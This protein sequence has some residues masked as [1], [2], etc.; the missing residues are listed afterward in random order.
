M[1]PLLILG[2]GV[3]AEEVADLAE[4]AGREIAGFVE[5]R[6][7]SRCTERLRSLPIHWIDDIAPL[8]G[9]CDAVCAVGS[10]ARSRF[11]GQARALGLGFVALAHP[12]AVVFPSASVSE[13]A[14]L[15]AS[16][17]VGAG[18]RIGA[19]AILNR[20]CLIGHH[21]RVGDYTTLGPGCNVGGLASVGSGCEIGMGAIVIDRVRIEDGA[22]AG[23]GALVNRD[24]AVGVRVVGAPARAV[25]TPGDE[26]GRGA[27]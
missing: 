2:T 20:G 6:D 18:A 23:A 9:E 5:G 24:V 26:L 22:S 13:G 19:H 3:F 12:S 27:S 17:V 15:G 7:R 4:A 14:I 21:V 16:V 10:G 25:R 11:I 1:R 8:A